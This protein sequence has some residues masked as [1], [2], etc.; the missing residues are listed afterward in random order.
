MVEPLPIEIEADERDDE[1]ALDPEL[2]AAVVESV[3]AGDRVGVLALIADLHVADLADLIEQIDSDH[4][5]RFIDL[6]WVDIDHEILIEVEEGVRDE[7]LAFLAPEKLAETARDLDSDDVV[8]LLEDL[9]ED[10]QRQ[11]LASLEPADRAAVA[12]SL[13]YPEGTAG[14]LMQGEVVKAPP[15]WTVG[16]M[17]DFLRASEDLP[18]DFYDIII[19]DPAA[20]PIGTVPLSV[21][22]GARRPVTLESLMADDFRTLHVEEDEEDVAYAFNQYHLVSAPVVDDSGRLI[23]VI[24]ID[25]AMDVLE[26]EAEEDLMRLGGVGDEEISDKVWAITRRRFPWLAANLVT[27]IAASLVIAIFDE[28]ISRFVALAILMP[29]VASMGGN[30]GTQTLT[31]AVRALATRDLTATNAMRV[32]ARE[33]LV[34]LGNGLVFAVIMGA[35]AWGWFGNPLLGGVIAAAMVVNLL[36]AGLAGILIPIGLDRL[37]ADPALASGTFVTTVTDVVGFFVFL[38]LAAAV[39]L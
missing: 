3:D 6:V 8:Y 34:G 10:T 27:A 24:T 26:D 22:L 13:A 32:V 23:G 31:V 7:I 4:R 15:F 14:R 12:K 30:A 20:K 38:G 37:G 19:V 11:V 16:Q 25:D 21:L 28:T 18:E 36:I 9:E 29:I 1:Y 33:T 2:V 39:L 35:V 17:I 5:R